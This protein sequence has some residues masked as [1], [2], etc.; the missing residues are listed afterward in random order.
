MFLYTFT[1]MNLSRRGFV[2]SVLFFAFKCLVY[3]QEASSDTLN[4][5]EITAI[6][7]ANITGEV[8]KTNKIISENRRWLNAFTKTNKIL[9]D[10]GLIEQD[11]KKISNTK[12]KFEVDWLTQRSLGGLQRKWR[13]VLARSQR[14]ESELSSSQKEIDQR[15]LNLEE[16]NLKW[17]LTQDKFTTVDAPARIIDIGKE[18]GESV[19]KELTVLKDTLDV[20][21]R[22]VDKN[23]NLRVQIERELD[24][25]E[26]NEVRNLSNLFVK[27]SEPFLEE[28]D[29]ITVIQGVAGSEVS[30][31][32]ELKI[33]SK[34]YVRGVPGRVFFHFILGIILL[35]S[36]FIMQKNLSK[37]ENESFGSGLM[38]QTLNQPIGNTILVSAFISFFLYSGLPI[39]LSELVLL[40]MI[41]FFPMYGFLFSFNYRPFI[42]AVMGVFFLEQV[43]SLSGLDLRYHRLGLLIEGIV[44][45]LG[46]LGSIILIRRD[47]QI[48]GALIE[49]LLAF[50]ARLTLIL[51]IV[52]V[53]ANLSDRID[54]ANYLIKGFI[55]TGII[56]IL[57]LILYDIFKAAIGSLVTSRSASFFRSIQ[58]HKERIFKGAVTLLKAG[59]IYLISNAFLGQF[60][61]KSIAKSWFEGV[62]SFGISMGT[63]D[64]TVGDIGGFLLI[65][66]TTLY[67]SSGVRFLLEEEILNR[68]NLKR[69]VP[70]ALALMGKYLVLVLGFL[71]AVSAAGVDLEKFGFIAGALGVG[72][73]FGLQNI[74]GNFV[75]GLV[76][77]FERPIH[78]GDIILMQNLEGTV[79]EIG[80]RATKIRTYE[81]AEVIIPNGDFISQQ[82]TNWTLSDN[83]RRMEQIVETRPDYKPQVV[84]EVLKKAITENEN[85]LLDPEPMVIF[86]GVEGN[87][88]QYRLLFW[89]TKNLLHTRTQVSLSINEK[90]K[91]EGIELALPK[92]E[93]TLQD[94]KG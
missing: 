34:E 58:S 78:V 77:M 3:G 70:M 60:A 39:G 82:V 35:I 69:G 90:L 85:I 59:S 72:I 51:G 30:F 75:A 65:I 79:T 68:L 55:K 25:I 16:E 2:L 42:Y 32:S 92:S 45:F 48:K 43:Q 93:V 7:I 88:H 26:V 66:I 31:F 19:E 94:K 46:S 6:E 47:R 36:F 80:I 8:Q 89:V 13:Q 9:V 20:I 24:L 54:L 53:Y 61:L 15:M 4:L 17:K 14:V 23:T 71:L 64:I 57:I 12:L 86:Q 21:F 73:G 37:L 22:L 1:R 40:V 27:R 44:I 5:S 81:G 62:L 33:E 11:I 50:G 67:L 28:S 38:N 56:V 29:S 87:K 41:F 52:S 74:V 63:L 83:K 76:L 10:L 91:E 18:I 49:K 84:M